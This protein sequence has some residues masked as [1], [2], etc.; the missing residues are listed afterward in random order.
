MSQGTWLRIL[1]ALAVTAIGLALGGA[2]ALAGTQQSAAPRGETPPTLENHLTCITATR[3]AERRYQLAPHL[4]GAVSLT[5]TGRW[6]VDH[7]ASLAWPWTVMAEGKGRYL[8]SKNVAIAEVKRLQARGIENIDV[9]C[10]QINLRYHADAFDDLD[11]AF[12][13]ATNADYAAAFLAEL[14]GN[15][16]AW[17]DAVALYHSRDEARGSAYRQKVFDIWYGQR[18]HLLASAEGEVLSRAT[19]VTHAA[20]AHTHEAHAA[21]NR[22]IEAARQANRVFL[23]Q[24]RALIEAR[25]RAAFEARKAKVLADWA[26]LKR[27]RASRKA[28]KS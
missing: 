1:L 19:A 9:G 12:D 11:A 14:K 4:L 20:L 24:Q 18:R 26:E 17:K 3:G 23:A 27:Q 7:R 16:G 5:E 2:I 10:L 25:E 15:G 8:P 13:P 21:R 22:V 28:G 6:S